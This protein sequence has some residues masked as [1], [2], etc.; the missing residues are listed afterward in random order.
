LAQIMGV[1][2]ASLARFE[3]EIEAEESA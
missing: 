2:A 1:P 3:E